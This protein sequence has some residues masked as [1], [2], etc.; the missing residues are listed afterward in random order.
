[1]EFAW[2]L[3]DIEQHQS[4][5]LVE[6]QDTDVTFAYLEEVEV[7]TTLDHRWWSLDDL[8]DT[9][10]HV[11]DNQLGVIESLLAQLI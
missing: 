2:A 5:Y 1:V 6:V 10:E 4:Y 9:T 8:R 11:L 3:Y 7:A